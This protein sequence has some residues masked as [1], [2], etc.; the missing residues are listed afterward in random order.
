MRAYGDRFRARGVC[1]GNISNEGEGEGSVWERGV[2]GL[3][4]SQETQ[5]PA[6][7]MAG[8]EFAALCTVGFVGDSTSVWS[9]GFG[10]AEVSSRRAGSSS[11]WIVAVAVVP[12]EGCVLGEREGLEVTSACKRGRR[13]SAVGSSGSRRG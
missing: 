5:A 9:L 2:D 4:D 6:L 12:S 13:V 8:G 1:V 10:A 3:A 11:S 7:P